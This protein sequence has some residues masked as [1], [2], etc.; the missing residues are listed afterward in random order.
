MADPPFQYILPLRLVLGIIA[1]SCQPPRV[2]LHVSS[3]SPQQAI[4]AFHAW[5]RELLLPG[6]QVV[7]S[8]SDDPELVMSSKMLKV[9]SALNP[10]YR[11]HVV[12][13]QLHF[14][15]EDYTNRV[16]PAA[17]REVLALANSAPAG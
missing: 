5:R 15:E 7:Q 2:Q 12:Q 10:Q 8:Q 16:K 14:L 17:W 6:H 13:L 3:S 9:F 1:I 4:E 11:Q